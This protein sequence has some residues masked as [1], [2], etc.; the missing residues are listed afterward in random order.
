M[1]TGE[2]KYL[3]PDNDPEVMEII[4]E[5]S[6]IRMRSERAR[7]YVLDAKPY[8]NETERL[9]HHDIAFNAICIAE[10]DALKRAKKAFFNVII[11][12]FPNDKAKILWSDFQ[13]EYTK[14]GD[15]DTV[16]AE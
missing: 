3:D 9:T 8:W 13:I 14:R 1:K 7:I 15:G 4:A 12:E 6:R 5:A 10:E 2:K 11:G 16:Y